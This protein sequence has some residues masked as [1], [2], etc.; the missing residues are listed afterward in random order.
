MFQNILIATDDSKTVQH[1]IRYAV[2]LFPK[3][4]F[5]II[6]VINTS[7]RSVPL[8]DLILED[9]KKFS[10]NAVGNAKNILVSEGAQC[11]E[12]AIRTGTPS[13]EVIKH[14]EENDIDLLIITRT[15]KECVP[16]IG[17]TCLSILEM[18]HC[19]V[20]IVPHETPLRVPKSVMNPTSGSSYSL[21]ASEMAVL[22]ADTFNAPLFSLYMGKGRGATAIG[23]IEAMAEKLGVA[24]SG[25]EA[26]QPI[27]RDILDC[28]RIHDIMVFS[29]GYAGI[30]YKLGKL[31][32]KMILGKLDR[33]VIGDANIPLLIVG[34]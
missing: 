32:K 10:E 4:S 13:R 26:K 3:A 17:A 15:A 19:P 12:T 33:E 30:R 27:D 14:I 7:D 1:A 31:K 34:D 22:M 23:A 11:V 29:R 25:R 6:S 21:S 9:L 5:H 28:A 18:V 2:R 20:L 24:F 8:T 16:H